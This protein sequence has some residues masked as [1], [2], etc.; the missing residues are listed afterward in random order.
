MKM[1]ITG[2]LIMVEGNHSKFRHKVI[3]RFLKQSRVYKPP[4]TRGPLPL[5]RTAQW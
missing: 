3:D 4:S 2:L 1:K 5:F